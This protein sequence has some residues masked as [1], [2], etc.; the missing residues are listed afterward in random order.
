MCACGHAHVGT[1]QQ[2]EDLAQFPLHLENW[3]T[4]ILKEHGLLPV[5][6]E[7]VR[8]R[9]ERDSVSVPIPLK[10]N[11]QSMRLAESDAKYFISRYNHYYGHQASLCNEGANKIKK[12]QWLK[13]DPRRIFMIIDFAMKALSQEY[14]EAMQS[15]FGKVGMVWFGAKVIWF[16]PTLNEFVYYYV[17]L[18]GTGT[19]EDAV[20]VCECLT[21]ILPLRSIIAGMGLESM[22]N[23]SK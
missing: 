10:P 16:D 3:V 19:C 7:N 12:Y 8:K 18:I 13:H 22:A 1:C 6:I 17:N 9:K 21:N 15:F 4:D 23:N 2:C 20:C 11:D 14:R 5:V